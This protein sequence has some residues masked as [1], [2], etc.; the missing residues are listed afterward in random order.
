MARTKQT[1]RKRN[2]DDGSNI[3]SHKASSTLQKEGSQKVAKLDDESNTKEEVTEQDE[4]LDDNSLFILYHCNRKLRYFVIP[5]SRF[6]GN[7]LEMLH[8]IQGFV[9]VVDPNTKA[10]LLNEMEKSLIEIS[11]Y[12]VMNADPQ[13]TLRYPHKN[14]AWA[15]YERKDSEE[16]NYHLNSRKPFPLKSVYTFGMIGVEK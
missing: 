13:I 11:S 5:S 3:S 12:L 16:W 7:D 4:S 2:D 14:G 1:A 15:F 8:R 9:K 10:V 6:T